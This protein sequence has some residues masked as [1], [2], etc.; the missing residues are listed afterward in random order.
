MLTLPFAQNHAVSWSSLHNIALSHLAS[1]VKTVVL[2]ALP[3]LLHLERHYKTKNEWLEATTDMRGPSGLL[4]TQPP[5]GGPHSRLDFS[6]VDECFARYE[7]WYNGEAVMLRYLRKDSAP[8][9]PLHLLV[10][11]KC[12]EMVNRRGLASIRVRRNRAAD[13]YEDARDYTRREV[14]T[15]CRDDGC[16]TWNEQALFRLFMY[17][18]GRSDATIPRFVFQHLDE[19]LDNGNRP[20]NRIASLNCLK[21]DL[22]SCLGCTEASRELCKSSPLAAWMDDVEEL[23]IFGSPCDSF[24]LQRLIKAPFPKLQKLTLEGVLID[25]SWLAIFLEDHW[26]TLTR[27]KIQDPAITVKPKNYGQL[28]LESDANYQ[29]IWTSFRKWIEERAALRGVTIE[30]SEKALSVSQLIEARRCKRLLAF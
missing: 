8:E 17:A 9:M 21:L 14:E 1:C 29:E 26:S 18:H 6:N 15:C 11:L 28:Q 19:L 10:N 3:T 16:R 12:V 27:V 5:D 20:P 2:S 13:G 7:Y 24:I 23:I 30:L 25:T 22:Q 4:I